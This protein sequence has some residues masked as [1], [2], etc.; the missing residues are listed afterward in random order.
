MYFLEHHSFHFLIC[1]QDG[2]LNYFILNNNIKHWRVKYIFCYQIISRRLY[3][4]NSPVIF[5]YALNFDPENGLPEVKH[6]R[7]TFHSTIRTA[8][9]YITNKPRP[10][11]PLILHP[12]SPP[13]WVQASP[14]NLPPLSKIGRPFRFLCTL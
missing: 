9:I 7:C 2:G 14:P 10:I 1:K 3:E 13:P 8:A 5:H 6:D 11:L 4:E 12:L